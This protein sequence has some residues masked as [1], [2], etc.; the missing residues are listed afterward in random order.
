MARLTNGISGAFHGKLGTVVGATWKGIP[1]MRSL[2]S[3]RTGAIS[4]HEK[5]N[6]HKFALSQA[7]LHPLL[8][9]L[10]EGYKGYSP[11]VEG[12]LAAKS[13]LHKHA[14]EGEGKQV[15]I[16]P[17]KMKVS[18]GNLPLPKAIAVA[19]KKPRELEFSW[20]GA[21][22]AG[23]PN[24][25]AMLLAYN[26]EKRIAVFKTA[27][28]FRST[29]RD[30]LTGLPAGNFHVY[31]AFVAWDRSHQSDSVYLGTTVIKT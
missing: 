14:F 13:Y 18:L 7:W 12:F 6:R 15:I 25:Q 29:G 20:N 24:D 4:I 16:N 3:K 23:H 10:R 19:H 27:G 31:V 5:N 26:V 28:Q 9:F 11:T 17:A 22:T 8:A 2:P 21:D 30:S 1:Y